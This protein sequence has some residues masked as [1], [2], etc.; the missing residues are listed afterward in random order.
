MPIE[1]SYMEWVQFWFPHD[2]YFHIPYDLRSEFLD[3]YQ[4]NPY[5]DIVWIHNNCPEHNNFILCK[6][7]RV[8]NDYQEE[9]EA[10]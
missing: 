6:E 3:A 2:E 9:S 7:R 5:L 4:N 8:I 1:V 10:A